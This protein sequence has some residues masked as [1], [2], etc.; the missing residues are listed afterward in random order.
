MSCGVP[1]Y[2]TRQQR[3]FYERI[4]AAY[5]PDGVLLVMHWND[6]Q[7]H[8][9]EVVATYREPSGV[10]TGNPTLVWNLAAA[11][12]AAHERTN[13][14]QMDQIGLELGRLDAAVRANGARLAIVLF[15]N[16]SDPGW[17]SL[18]ATVSSVLGVEGVP[19]L[20]LGET[21][22]AAAASQDLRVHESDPHPNEIAH[23]L[24][25]EEI[26]VFLR[27]NDLVPAR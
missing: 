20:D 16:D 10:V 26:A 2:G 3:L 15:R 9:D 22:L 19:I 11:D 12:S 21:L 23:R 6:G 24:A 14:L 4:A 17:A 7:L 27:R 8:R 25:A 5:A 1:G 18:S 13:D